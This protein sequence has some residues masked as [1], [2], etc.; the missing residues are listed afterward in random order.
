LD[1]KNPDLDDKPDAAT[2]LAGSQKNDDVVLMETLKIMG[3]FVELEKT[4]KP[5]ADAAGSSGKQS[6]DQ[7]VSE[8]IRSWIKESSL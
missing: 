4:S 7:G 1:K 3:D 2:S 8:R 5:V 6:M